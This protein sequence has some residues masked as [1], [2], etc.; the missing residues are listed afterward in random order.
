MDDPFAILVEELKIEPKSKAQ[1]TAE[2]EDDNNEEAAFIASINDMTSVSDLR[3][4]FITFYRLKE[5]E[6]YDLKSRFTDISRRQKEVFMEVEKRRKL[7]I[8]KGKKY[9]Q[10]AQ[11]LHDQVNNLNNDLKFERKKNSELSV[12]RDQKKQRE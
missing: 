1:S 6:I 4:S 10:T 11:K 5:S 12:I 8:S 9:K 7:A 2:P 3:D